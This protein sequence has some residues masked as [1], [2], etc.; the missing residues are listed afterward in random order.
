MSTNP[1]HHPAF[2]QPRDPESTILWRYMDVDKFKWL[3]SEGRLFMPAA[4]LLGDPFEGTTPQAE[5]Q[6]CDEAAKAASE[7]HRNILQLQ[8]RNES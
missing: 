5:L 7:E 4:E 3:V 2:P 1:N 8:I 6:W